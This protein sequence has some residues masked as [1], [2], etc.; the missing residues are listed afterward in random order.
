[1]CASEMQQFEMFSFFSMEV[2]DDE[3]IEQLM[4]ENS[5]CPVLR[6][7]LT[8]TTTPPSSATSAVAATVTVSPLSKPADKCVEN[9]EKQKGGV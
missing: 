5:C 8:A 4:K 2:L 6:A 9:G 7:A 1:M 3:Q